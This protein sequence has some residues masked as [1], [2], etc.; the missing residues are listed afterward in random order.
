MVS[1]TIDIFGGRG[2]DPIHP[3]QLLQL[4]ELSSSVHSANPNRAPTLPFSFNYDISCSN[5]S[6]QMELGPL[7]WFPAWTTQDP[8]P[9]TVLSLSPPSDGKL[10][11][12]RTLILT[13]SAVPS[14]VPST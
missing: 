3:Y 12:G 13:G 14:T 6:P 10:F 2:C 1:L 9:Q 4:L 11:Q 5:K 7:I 8:I